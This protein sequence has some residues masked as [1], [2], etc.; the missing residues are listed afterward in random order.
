MVVKDDL[1]SMG[2]C[3]WS[4]L[5]AAQ[6]GMCAAQRLCG[7]DQGNLQQLP[8]RKARGLQ[9]EPPETLALHLQLEPSARNKD[10]AQPKTIRRQSRAWAEDALPCQ[11]ELLPHCI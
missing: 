2:G 11:Q 10:D 9:L 4:A 7:V 1:R 8:G 5:F 6:P 3:W